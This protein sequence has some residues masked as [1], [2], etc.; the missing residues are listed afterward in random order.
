VCHWDALNEMNGPPVAA[1]RAESVRQLWY[2]AAEPVL[3][4]PQ[5][6]LKSFMAISPRLSLPG[7]W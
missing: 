2:A 6:E 7:P 5:I 3:G 4:N 1:I